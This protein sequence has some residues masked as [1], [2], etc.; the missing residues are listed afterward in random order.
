MKD[1]NDLTPQ[2]EEGRKYLDRLYRDA[3]EA[4]AQCPTVHQHIATEAWLRAVYESSI[5]KTECL[6]QMAY[7][8]VYLIPQ[9]VAAGVAR[10]DY[11]QRI[12]TGFEL[13]IR[14][15]RKANRTDLIGNLTQSNAPSAL[16]ELLLGAALAYQFGDE[17]IEPYP[18]IGDGQKTMEFAIQRAG[19][20]RLLV[21]AVTFYDDAASRKAS[22]Y[23][24]QH[25]IMPWMD[26]PDPSRDIQHVA[27]IAIDKATQRQPDAPFVLCL[28]QYATWPAA[29]DIVLAISKLVAGTVVS[30][31]SMLVG[32]FYFYH[33]NLVVSHLLD[34]LAKRHAVPSNLLGAC[35][36]AF[37][38]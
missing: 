3:L 32:C 28:C 15:A 31:D 38:T 5:A 7:P 26:F 11:L 18:K 13:V 24:R 27:K 22:E 19:E 20:S 29:D 6:A 33:D 25:K 36:D 1:W 17:A 35:R 12:E 37:N 23:R 16:F 14:K 8:V 9:F 4:F 21:E 34:A 30:H 10:R 2:D